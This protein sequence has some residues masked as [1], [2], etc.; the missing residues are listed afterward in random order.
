MSKAKTAVKLSDVEKT[1][2]DIQS[3]FGATSLMRM[4][5][6]TVENVPV[7]PTGSLALDRAIGIGGYPLGRIVEI[8]GPEAS[9]KTTLAL[10]AMANVQRVGGNVAIIDAEHA[11]DP[12]YA[13]ALGVAVDDVMLCQPDFGEQAL[14]IT[15]ELINSGNCQLVV[16]D[17]VAALVPKAELEGNSGDSHMGLQARLMGQAMRRITGIAHKNQVCVIFINQIRHK[18]GVMFGSPETTTGGNALKYYASLRLDIRRR[19]KIQEGDDTIGNLTEVKV[20]KNKF[21]PPF[22]SATFDI[23]YGKGIDTVGDLINAAVDSGIIKKEGAWYSHEG[24]KLGQGRRN[25]EALFKQDIERRT[26]IH[27]QVRAVWLK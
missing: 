6:R 27:Q 8:Y 2:A 26:K 20:V 25:V 24:E 11:L 19:D 14:D 15:C 4:G 16:V 5:Q 22:R 12:A 21:Y 10:S 13:D 3:K 18:I 23:I 9:G 17:S 7:I 1:V